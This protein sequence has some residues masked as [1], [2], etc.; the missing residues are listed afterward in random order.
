MVFPPFLPLPLEGT[1]LPSLFFPHVPVL[2][3]PLLL[4]HPTLS[5]SLFIHA[6]EEALN[7]AAASTHSCEEQVGEDVESE[8]LFCKRK[9]EDR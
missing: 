7:S 8:K 4:T 3:L 1:M 9:E 2:L 6:E 5:P